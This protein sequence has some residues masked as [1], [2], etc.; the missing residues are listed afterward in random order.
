MLSPKLRDILEIL[1]RPPLLPDAW[2]L[3]FFHMFSVFLS[4]FVPVQ[5]K[6]F[7]PLGLL[8]CSCFHG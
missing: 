2:L 1:V 8:V 7:E 6:F 4:R 3:T 5:M